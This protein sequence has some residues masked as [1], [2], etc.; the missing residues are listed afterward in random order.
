MPKKFKTISQ[1]ALPPPED[2][3]LADPLLVERTRFSPSR[4]HRYTLFR[5]WGNPENYCVFIGMNPSGAGVLDT[6][7]TISKCCKFAKRWGFDGLYM[8]NAFALRATNSDELYL[9]PDPVGPEN[10]RWIREIA[11]GARKV[12]VAWGVP[13]GD[14]QRGA[15]MRDILLSTCGPEKV[16]CFGY[17]KDGTPVHPLY[18]PDDRE[19][20]CFFKPALAS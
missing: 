18:Q 2:L 7:R 5:Y 15:Q 19:L 4:T 12:V 1:S 11:I 3:S 9:S 17:N 16:F 14:F 10:D 6:D 20:E 8:L 13:G